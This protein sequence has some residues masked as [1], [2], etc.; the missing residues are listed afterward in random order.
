MVIIYQI[1]KEKYMTL[2]HVF[3]QEKP[4]M[5]TTDG[6]LQDVQKS[7][8]AVKDLEEVIRKRAY[9]IYLEYGDDYQGG[10]T[11]WLQAEQEIRK[12]YKR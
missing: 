2:R 11:H 8:D 10:V 4:R 12:K 6:H 3:G 5:K 9:E 7:Y 1:V